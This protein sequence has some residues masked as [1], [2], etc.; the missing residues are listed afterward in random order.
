MDKL[1]LANIQ[2][3]AASV[4]YG[5]SGSLEPASAALGLS[6]ALFLSN[7]D[8]WQGAGYSLTE[9]EID[10]IQA[11]IA[12]LEN[13]LIETGVMYPMDMVRLTTSANITVP[14]ATNTSWDFDVEIY[15]PEDMHSLAVQPP[16]I[17]PVNAG[18]TIFQGGILWAANAVGSRELKLWRVRAAVSTLLGYASVAPVSA[19]ISIYQLVNVQDNAELGDYYY[20]QAKQSSGANLDI[21]QTHEFPV[22]AAVRV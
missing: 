9:A 13:D 4:D 5:G 17:T 2:A 16:R 8:L 1:V 11:M 21:L 20:L 7:L 12:Q 18:L 6:A 3:L 14:T 15:D 22:F 19:A 10:D